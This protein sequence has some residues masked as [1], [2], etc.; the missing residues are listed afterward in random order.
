MKCLKTKTPKTTGFKRP[1]IAPRK[2]QSI[3]DPSATDAAEAG[4]S[5]LS[6]TTET[7]NSTTVRVSSGIADEKIQATD[8]LDDLTN[9]SLPTVFG[10]AE[11]NVEFDGTEFVS[12][13]FATEFK[14]ALE[15]TPK[16]H[17]VGA[18]KENEAEA[19]RIMQRDHN[20]ATNAEKENSTTPPGIGPHDDGLAPVDKP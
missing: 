12:V 9:L 17:S 7:T 8:D 14:K 5:G 2:I 6:T 18:K 3:P 1:Y 19:S 13:D 16:P 15:Q 4:Q 11:I 10:D 20:Y